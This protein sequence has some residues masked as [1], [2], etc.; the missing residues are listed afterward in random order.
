MKTH[1]IVWRE[2][3]AVALG[4]LVCCALLAA[5]YA[6]LGRF[7]VQILYSALAGGLLATANFCIMALGA[8]VA[9]DKGQ[10]Q[11]VKGGQALITM[12]YLGRM[13]GLFVI[14][15]LCA[16]TGVF[17]LIALVL[18]LVFVRPILTIRELLHKKG[19]E[20]K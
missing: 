8:D 12:S 16:K 10:Q 19:A 18:P 2:T 14:L 13:A 15:A 6:L 5:V 20:P 7:S 4:Q 3:G 1:P 9:A 17:D 11:D